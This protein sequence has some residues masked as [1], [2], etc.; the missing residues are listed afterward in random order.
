VLVSNVGASFVPTFPLARAL[1]GSR[2]VDTEE[3]HSELGAWRLPFYMA[4]PYGRFD[5]PEQAADFP[6]WWRTYSRGYA[7]TPIAVGY[8]SDGVIAYMKDE[9]DEIQG[10]FKSVDVPMGNQTAVAN[11]TIVTFR[12]APMSVVDLTNP[13]DFKDYSG[14]QMITKQG[15]TPFESRSEFIGRGFLTTFLHRT[16]TPSSSFRPAPRTTTRRGRLARSCWASRAPRR[17]TRPTWKR[18]AAAT[19]SPITLS[20]PRYHSRRR[21]P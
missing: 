10:L 2:S 12:A 15:L 1:V 17:L 3:Q 4:D 5:L 7:Y 16:S 21:A 19:W 9:G 18:A 8:G 6:G 11:T 20:S 14:V 13:Q